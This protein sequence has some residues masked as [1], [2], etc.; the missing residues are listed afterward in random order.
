MAVASQLIDH[1][2]VGRFV[3]RQL[4][5]QECQALPP[6]SAV[7][8]QAKEQMVCP[9]RWAVVDANFI[10]SLNQD[11]KPCKKCIHAF[12]GMTPKRIQ[13][14]ELAVGFFIIQVGKC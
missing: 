1:M 5:I 8:L 14:V 9:L 4:T 12:V 11:G 13:V 3:L 2:C 10:G 6:R 7:K